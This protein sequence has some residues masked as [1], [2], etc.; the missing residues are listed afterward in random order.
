MQLLILKRNSLLHIESKKYLCVKKADNWNRYRK[1]LKE[2]E[3]RTRKII[4]EIIVE[5]SCKIYDTSA[6]Y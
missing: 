1:Q 6:T 4:V 3:T 5:N 2:L